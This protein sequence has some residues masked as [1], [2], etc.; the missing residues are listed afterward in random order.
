M[1]Y[2]C[3][4]LKRIIFKGAKLMENKLI[5]KNRKRMSE[6]IK[7]TNAIVGRNIRMEREERGLSVKQLADTLGLS[8]QFI[9]LLERGERGTTI[10]NMLIIS[11]AF[12]ITLDD[13]VGLGNMKLA[14]CDGLE[15][16]RLKLKRKAINTYLYNMTGEELDFVINMLKGFR[17]YCGVKKLL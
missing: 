1:V 17:K 6:K 11:T 9:G 12:Q 3:I 2:Y 4:E 5:E 10:E 14:E 15:D 8:P 13:L 16:P 7:H